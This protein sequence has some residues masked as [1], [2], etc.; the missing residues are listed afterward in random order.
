[1]MRRAGRKLVELGNVRNRKLVLA[2]FERGDVLSN[3]RDVVDR[4][5]ADRRCQRLGALR[6][7]G[8]DFEIRRRSP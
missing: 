3:D 6:E 8:F 1:M 5:R 2:V 7:L 4:H